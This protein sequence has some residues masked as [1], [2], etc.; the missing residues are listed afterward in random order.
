MMPVIR[1]FSA[2]PVFPAGP[3][4]VVPAAGPDGSG[5]LAAFRMSD[6]HRAWQVTI[7]EP[8]AAAPS[9][10]PGGMLV[11]CAISLGAP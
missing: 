11:N 4:L 7:P 9:A 2:V 3:L 5:L 1:A 10:V 6:G 8:L